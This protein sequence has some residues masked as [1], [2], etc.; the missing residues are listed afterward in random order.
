MKWSILNSDVSNTAVYCIA[1]ELA[2]IHHYL[3]SEIVV[4]LYVGMLGSCVAVLAMAVVYEG[5]KVARQWLTLFTVKCNCNPQ[6]VN[7]SETPVDD[8]LIVLTPPSLLTELVCSSVV[9]VQ[10]KPQY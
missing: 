7:R 2:A 8:E 1:C 6:E 3:Y 9:H 5:I 10:C 4:S